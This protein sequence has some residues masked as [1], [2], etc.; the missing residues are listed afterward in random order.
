MSE[1]NKS[2]TVAATSMNAESS[3]SHAVFNVLMTQSQLD[4]ATQ[5]SVWT[6]GRS[7]GIFLC[8]FDQIIYFNIDHFEI[9]IN[10]TI[11]T[12]IWNCPFYLNLS[13]MK[14]LGHRE[15]I[16]ENCRS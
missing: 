14:N 9:V 3:R 12:M 2:R 4:E 13:D 15:E 8:L 10:I 11:F 5:V 1:G 6:E 7:T 16:I